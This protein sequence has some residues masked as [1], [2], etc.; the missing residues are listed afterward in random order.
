[1]TVLD[2]QPGT[3]LPDFNVGPIRIGWSIQVDKQY[4]SGFL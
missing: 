1:M 4:H 3:L 2:G